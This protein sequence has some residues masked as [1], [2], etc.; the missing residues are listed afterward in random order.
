MLGVMRTTAL[1]YQCS[2]DTVQCRSF[3]PVAVQNNAY[4]LLNGER[5]AG[6]AADILDHL[7]N[8]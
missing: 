5:A 1:I 4:L 6:V 2:C 3:R 8:V 7:F